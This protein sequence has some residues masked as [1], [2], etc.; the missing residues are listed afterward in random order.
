[1]QTAISCRYTELPTT[2]CPPNY[3]ITYPGYCPHIIFVTKH[4]HFFKLWIF[5]NTLQTVVEC[6]GTLRIV[7]LGSTFFIP[8]WFPLQS[9]ITFIIFFLLVLEK[10]CYKIANTYL[11]KLVWTEIVLFFSLQCLNRLR[12]NG[13]GKKLLG[14]RYIILFSMT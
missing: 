2:L 1:M 5:E 6:K 4:L 7:T 8:P 12:S 13:V 14:I 10:F 11:E 3:S 9:R